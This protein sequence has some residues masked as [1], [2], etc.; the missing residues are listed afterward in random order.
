M[1][2]IQAVTSDLVDAAKVD[3]QYSWEVA[4]GY[5]LVVELDEAVE[6]LENAVRLP[7]LPLSLGVRPPAREPPQRRTV[8]GSDGA[9]AKEIRSPRSLTIRSA[10]L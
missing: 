8:P 4:A 5:A 6:W 1:R 10:V 2:A 9:G 3:W 7:Q